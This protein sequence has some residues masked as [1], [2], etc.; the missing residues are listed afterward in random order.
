MAL[1]EYQAKRTFEVTPEPTG[2]AG[3]GPLRFVVQ[4][5]DASRLHYDFRLEMGGVL[6]SWAVPKG[7]SLNPHDKRLAMMTEDHP[8]DYRTFEGIIPKG[9]YGAGSVIV[10]DEG[11]YE[12]LGA[13][14]DRESDDKLARQGVHQGHLTFILHGH[15]LNGEFALVKMH[16]EQAEENAWL[17]VKAEKDEF[18]GETDVTAQDR[19]VVTQRT[20]AEVAAGAPVQVVAL[21]ELAA[22]PAGPMPEEFA[23][24][25]ASLAEQPFD[26]ADWLYEI[27]WDGYRIL[28]EVGT[29]GVK[30]HSRGQQ[31]YTREF[32]PV[33]EE[34]AGLQIPALIDGEVCVVDDAGRPSFQDLQQYLKTGRG[35]LVYYAFDLLHFDGHDTSALPLV[36]R[37]ALL[38]RLLPTGPYVKFSDHV[39][40]QGAALLASARGQGLEGVMAKRAGSAYAFGRRSQDWLKFKVKRR[41]EAVVV[42]WT[43]PRA[44]RQYFG[45]LVLGIYDDA[46]KLVYAGHSGSGFRDAELQDLHARLEQLAQATCS[47]DPEPKT[48]EPAHWVKPELV[49]EIEFTEWTE[50]GSMRHPIFVGLR[51]DKNPREVTRERPAESVA[52]AAASEDPESDSAVLE[53]NGHEIQVTHRHKVFF[54]ENGYTKGQLL[55]YYAEIAPTI[56][57]YLCDRPESLHRF[58]GGIHG[59]NFYH[60]DLTDTAPDWAATQVVHSDSEERDLTYILCQD[61]AT[62]L[63]LVNLGCVELNPWNSRVGQ[64]ERPDWCVIDL[65]PE[66]IG[67]EQVVTV[68]RTVHEV[69]EEA[70]VRSYPKTSGATGLHI[71]IPMGAR[72]SYDQVR[73]FGHIVGGLVHARLPEITS[74]ERSPSKRQKRVYLDYLQNRRGQTLAAPYSVRP[75]PGAP[76]SAPLDWAEVQPGL[77]PEHFTMMNIQARLA[78]VGDLWAPVIGEGIDLAKAL[79]GLGG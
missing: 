49:A 56:L 19:S 34:L 7:P 57:P 8:Y 31:D 13:T 47:I 10:W 42:G 71:Y 65:D 33:A 63:Y 48:N 25:L 27:K 11:T 58:P 26:Q 22:A 1:E 28:A 44:G 4:K 50:D 23:P 37:K 12:P 52:P 45:A 35:S 62:L 36:E 77:R 60:K 64:L 29:K 67:F 21:E 74:L 51:E 2:G 39:V 59:Q 5:H 79:E 24:M 46:G 32:A 55:D 54:P 17:L 20:V 9:N 53:V 66:D 68:A 72:Y 69:L 40:G 61:E 73:D 76:V 3:S 18:A 6:K 38:R 41:Q 78:S 75:R 14:G 16:G 15:K 43:E 70:G 30:L